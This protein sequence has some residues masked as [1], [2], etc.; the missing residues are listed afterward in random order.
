[1]ILLSGS[2]FLQDLHRR[3]L[4]DGRLHLV[5]TA[6][7]A[8]IAGGFSGLKIDEWGSLTIGSW[9]GGLLSA[10]IAAALWL[11]LGAL[12]YRVSQAAYRSYIATLLVDT[13]LL[14]LVL[15]HDSHEALRP[16]KR[17]ELWTQLKLSAGSE[18]SFRGRVLCFL[19]TYSACA[20]ALGFHPYPA[21]WR[22][23][24]RWLDYALLLAVP[25]F[26]FVVYV[27]VMDALAYNT[28]DAPLLKPL[29]GF[30]LL[31]TLI[32]ATRGMA[33]R[34]GLWLA[35]VD[36]LLGEVDLGRPLLAR[37]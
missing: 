4:G 33:R 21:L 26:S 36:V 15:E 11:A 35:L 9:R 14:Y 25:A 3:A 31:L 37:R 12:L 8:A 2:A 29:G 1:M 5:E 7:I 30:V 34:S 23:I 17:R 24:G 28:V 18:L 16:L 10:A 27:A 20:G 6:A 19:R 32:R 13:G 22:N